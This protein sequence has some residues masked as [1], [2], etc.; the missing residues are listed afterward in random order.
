[1]TRFILAVLAVLFP[2][3]A[4]AQSAYVIAGAGFAKTEAAGSSQTTVPAFA[5][6]GYKLSSSVAIE[7]IY[8]DLDTGRDHI[9]SSSSTAPLSGGGTTI[10]ST[11][12]QWR[13]KGPGAFLVGMHPISP[14]MSLVGKLG[15]Y[16]IKSETTNSTLVS[17]FPTVGAFTSS[18][19]ETTTTETISAPSIAIGLQEKASERVGIRAMLERV[20]GHGDFK[21]ATNISVGILFSF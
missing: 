4:A 11:K 7:A 5:G 2:I 3:Y 13:G 6:F 8:A 20:G 10:T 19:T 17:N 1:M 18:A 21:H 15:L 9:Q 16:R 14:T 12:T